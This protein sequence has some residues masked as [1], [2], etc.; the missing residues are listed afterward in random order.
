MELAINKAKSILNP[1]KN[2]SQAIIFLSL[3]ALSAFPAQASPI[4][5]GKSFA[6]WCAQKDVVSSNTRQTIEVLLQQA[7]TTNCQQADLKLSQFAKL[8]LHNKKISDLRPFASFHKLEW[9]FLSNNQILDLEPLSDLKNLKEL[10]LATNE[11]RVLTPLAKLSNLEK[12]DLRNNQISNLQP[13][14]NLNDL[15]VLDLRNNRIAN[16]APISR[17]KSLPHLF[18]SNNQI[19]DLRPLSNMG[20]STLYLDNNQIRDIHP[21]SGLNLLTLHLSNNPI[22]GIS[23]DLDRSPSG[24]ITGPADPS[25]FPSANTGSVPHDDTQTHQ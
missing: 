7:G 4:Q 15:R 2:A 9:L 5:P 1:M 22:S 14:A 24:V 11:I 3:V 8:N 12:I 21:L 19:S 13:L 20:L 6:Q 10:Y 16:L 25:Q 18:L 17:L 23:Q